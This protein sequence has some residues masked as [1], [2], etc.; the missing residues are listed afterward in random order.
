MPGVITEDNYD[1]FEEMGMFPLTD[2]DSVDPDD[3]NYVQNEQNNEVTLHGW[4]PL[5]TLRQRRHRKLSAVPDVGLDVLS[6]NVHPMSVS[7]AEI[8]NTSPSPFSPDTPSPKM[9]WLKAFKK[10][11]TMNDPWAKYRIEDR[12]LETAE[13]HR[14]NA[15]KKQWF[16]DE[17]KVRMEEEVGSF[18]GP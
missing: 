14:Y 7:S 9:N 11:R 3:A 16:K 1:E 17:I 12:P 18:H 13:R 15:L 5:M 6:H 8:D 10:I 4:K 2:L